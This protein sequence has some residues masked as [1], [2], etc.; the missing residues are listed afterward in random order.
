[1]AV[2]FPEVSSMSTSAAQEIAQWST[3]GVRAPERLDYWASTL[4]SAMIPLY[5]KDTNVATF[6]SQMSVAS[7]GALSLVRQSGSPH[8][9][10][11]GRGELS[12]SAQRSYNLMVSL[13]HGYA[14]EHRN[15][16]R[17]RPGDL[18][19]TDSE[20]PMEIALRDWYEFVNVAIPVEWLRTWVPNVH[21]LVGRR[22]PGDST[23][24]RALSSYLGML[25]PQVNLHLPLPHEAVADHVGALLALTMDELRG[26][27]DTGRRRP[28]HSL[29][30]R[31]AELIVQRCQEPA[32][33]AA[34]V[35]ESAGVSVRTLHRALAAG[36]NTF[37]GLLLEARAR[38]GV[39]MLQSPLFRRIT[40]AEIG[41]R[42]GF[43]DA[44]H[45]TK[46]LRK[47]HGATPMQ[48]RA[49]PLEGDAGATASSDL[50]AGPAHPD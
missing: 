24:G 12:R 26:A 9:C 33:S 18:T 13:N 31:V 38:C 41:R 49:V 48:L 20:Y 14:L 35:A 3:Y 43:S 50:Q 6:E 11:R 21:W 28:E 27:G 1:M 2:T 36:G 23:W 22:I 7:L 30:D 46:V 8:K 10:G 39:R 15:D 32:L 25:A 19:L 16:V 40:V 29:R 47:L 34:A 45:F 42:A 4:S 17:L 44:S 37:A 5:V